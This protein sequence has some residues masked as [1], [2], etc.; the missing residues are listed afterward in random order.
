MIAMG[1]W[2]L[3]LRYRGRLLT[4]KTFHRAALVMAPSGFV[5]V[6]AGWF[7]TEIGR[8][9]FT[10]YGLL[11]TADS[12]SPI[13]APAVATSLALFV[14]VYLIVFGAGT[15]YVLRLLSKPPE[16]DEA[17]VEPGTVTRTAGIT[18]APGLAGSSDRQ[19]R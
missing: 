8:Q 1:V 9:P 4:S 16:P 5:A 7:T 15:W 2:S 3:W 19:E 17:G 14:V 10:V 11:R 12:V 18:P 13:A 6:L